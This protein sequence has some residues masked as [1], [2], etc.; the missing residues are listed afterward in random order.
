MANRNDL[1]IGDADRLYGVDTA[2]RVY[3][4]PPYNQ[5]AL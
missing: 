4:T 1:P 3:H 5:Y 2:R